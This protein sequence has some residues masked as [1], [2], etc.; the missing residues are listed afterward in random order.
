[1][2]VKDKKVAELRTIDDKIDFRGKNVLVRVDADVAVD[3]KGNVE[4]GGEQRLFGC[5]KTIK[6]LI[7]KG[8]RIVLMSHLGRPNGVVENLRITPL[9]K[10]LSEHLGLSI[11]CLDEVVGSNVKKVVS[12]MKNGDVVFLENLRFDARE[13]KNDS[14]F[15]QELASL[16]QIYINESFATAHREHASVAAITEFLPSYA[17]YLFAHEVEVLS[18]VFKNPKRPV[19]AAISGAKIETKAALLKNLLSQVDYLL[20]GGGVANMFIQAKGLRIGSSISEPSMLEFV[21]E[22]LRD[23]PNKIFVPTDVKVSRQE[24]DG[25]TSV[26]VLNS[27]NVQDNDA[28]YD[29]G[30]QTSEIYAN[31]VSLSKTCIWNGPMGKTELPDFQ[32]G[33]KKL[34][35][36]MLASGVY[37]VVGGGN[38]IA[39]LQEM[40]LLAGFGHVSTGGGAM[41]AFLEGEKMPAVDALTY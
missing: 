37:V 15:A 26:M 8:A 29:I 24:Q 6:F 2:A 33:T 41:I 22:L 5:E 3:E 28:I 17:G 14:N 27:E 31:I 19:L 11:S 40:S 32:E 30:P 36:A 35:K 18:E 1:M 9:A 39:A 7:N 21:K 13:E 25:K 38:T 4:P 20:T 16:G 12:E 34:A 10:R 23:F